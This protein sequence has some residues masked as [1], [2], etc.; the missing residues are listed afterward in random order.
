MVKENG[1]VVR[2]LRVPVLDLVDLNG[3]S[4][5]GWGQAAA[6]QGSP[7]TK[8]ANMKLTYL[9]LLAATAAVLV[10][11]SSA[12]ARSFPTTITHDGSVALG[13]TGI[14]V[15]SGRVRSPKPFCQLFR[16]VKLVGHYP[17]GT[18]KLLDVDFTSVKGAWGTKA[19]LTG[20][21][22]VTARATRFAFRRHGH[23]KVCL[24]DA[25][26]FVPGP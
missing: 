10:C 5:R 18:T 7:P 11:A 26:S 16:I 15:D 3:Y 6:T 21:D 22:R 1:I 4:R 8:G 20:A 17:G 2:H 24:A 14:S 13:T 9:A 19:D 23:R 12:M 25:V